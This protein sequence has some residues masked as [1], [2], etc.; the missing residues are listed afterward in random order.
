M[1]PIYFCSLSK[2][3]KQCFLDSFD[4]ILTDCDGVLW[5]AQGMIKGAAE[6]VNSWV[7]M[8][9][10]VF[11]VTNNSTKTKKQFLDKCH[12]LGFIA[13]EDS[14]CNTSSLAAHYLKGILPPSKWVYVVGA[15]SLEEDLNNQAIPNFGAGKDE[16]V[17]NILDNIGNLTIEMKKNVGAVLVG[18]DGFIN[19]IKM[20]K[21]TTYLKNDTCLFVCTNKD[22]TF[23]SSEEWVMPGTGAIVAGI[24][25]ASGR[26]PFVV[27]KPSTYLA[28]YLTS[29]YNIDP[30]RTLFIGDRCN[31]DILMGNKCFFKTL[32]VLSGVHSLEDVHKYESSSSENDLLSV[33]Q[34]YTNS[35]AD[36]SSYL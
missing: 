3:E 17:E 10:R 18:F 30:S 29:K 13:S 4:T 27:G 34:Y 5:N 2:K 21:A 28:Q 36:L 23:P 11:Y 7:S 25:V 35:I 22:E 6:V 9:K 26:E 20:L 32:L 1:S 15:Q 31:T 16:S 19:Y 24:E 12:D 33:P 14:I 8:G